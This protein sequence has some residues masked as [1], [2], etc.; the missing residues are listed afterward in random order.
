ML[1]E[2]YPKPS[3]FYQSPRFEGQRAELVAPDTDLSHV[4]LLNADEALR[5]RILSQ[6]GLFKFRR[7]GR[8]HGEY[9]LQNRCLLALDRHGVPLMLNCDAN[10]DWAMTS[11]F[12]EI[13]AHCTQPLFKLYR[14]ALLEKW[15]EAPAADGL[16]VLGATHADHN[17]YHFSLCLLPLIRH[18]PDHTSTRI[19]LPAQCLERPFQLDLVR[20]TFG[21][22]TIVALPDGARVRD[23]MLIYEPVTADAIRW[24]RKRTGLRAARGNRLIHIAR[25]SSQTGRVGGCL[26]E[27]EAFLAFLARHG[28]ETV[29]FGVGTVLL[30]EQVALLEGARVVLAAHGANMTNLAY[31]DPGVSV[32]EVMPYYWTYF[33][34]MQIACAVG[35][36]YVGVVCHDVN[37]GQN[38]VPDVASLEQALDL[39]LAATPAHER[40]GKFFPSE[41]EVACPW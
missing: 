22:R 21:H 34:H 20:L 28:F 9:L 6:L 14:N 24:L 13:E 12:G 29:D 2:I 19:G 36:P 38:M 11:L 32:I 8:L 10:D 40:T 1:P 3:A 15:D 23:P 7:F 26:E 27:T 30:M 16:V 5:A 35:L 31:L 33:S 41:P 18:F 17:F 4:T 37:A 39:A 25:R